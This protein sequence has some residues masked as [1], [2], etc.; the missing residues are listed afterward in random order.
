M[1]IWQNMKPEIESSFRQR[2][3]E[4]VLAVFQEIPQPS[5]S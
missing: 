5:F 1:K 3:P 4:K 2:G